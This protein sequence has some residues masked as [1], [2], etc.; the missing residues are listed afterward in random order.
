MKQSTDK[1]NQ[2]IERMTT[3]FKINHASDNAANYSIARK[4][5]TQISSLEIAESNIMMGSDLLETAESNS[6]LINQHVSRIR[7]LVEQASNG[8]YGDES[9]KA[10]QSEINSRIEEINRIKNTSEYNGLSLFGDYSA[11]VLGSNGLFANSVQ[12]TTDNV[13]DGYTAVTNADELRTALE[14]NENIVLLNDIDMSSINNWSNISPA[15]YSATLDGNGYTIQNLDCSGDASNN[16]GLF[17][18]AGNGTV[19]KNLKMTNVTDYSYY[20]SPGVL[21]TVAE[22]GASIIIDNCSIHIAMTASNY[23]YGGGFVSTIN[24]GANTVF[25]KQIVKKTH[26]LCCNLFSYFFLK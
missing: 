19:I 3:G 12:I 13:P 20:G 5:D 10:I 21:F 7:D 8:T 9:I 2:A 18:T 6:E 4:L 24:S 1:L 17:E 16:A 15:Y 23:N 25:N 14:N 11:K 22:S 26:K